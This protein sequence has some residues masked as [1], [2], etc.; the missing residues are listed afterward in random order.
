MNSILWN[1]QAPEGS[2]IYIESGA[3]DVTYSDVMG[4]W[5]GTGNLNANPKLISLFSLLNHNSPCIDS[6]NPDMMYN[7]P[8]SSIFPGY[9]KLPA[10]GTVRNDMGAYGGPYADGWWNFFNFRKEMESAENYEE[11]NVNAY[12]PESITLGQYPN[13]FNPATK[14]TYTLPQQA[15]VTLQVFDML[16]NEIKT[17]VKE[18]QQPGS[19]EVE[20]DGSGLASGMYL[21]RLQVGSLV[22]T[23]KMLLLK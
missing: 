23:R 12:L 21:C 10:R 1:N 20:F 11:D 19:Y 8:E 13:P 5:T 17:L 15:D 3:I 22:E 7:D 16:G 6:G 18:T 9:A 4:G 14:I 2:E